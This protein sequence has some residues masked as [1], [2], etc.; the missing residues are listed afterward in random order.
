VG[1]APSNAGMSL[2]LIWLT[3]ILVII[4]LTQNAR[5]LKHSAMTIKLVGLALILV[6]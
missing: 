4:A 6:L 2:K 5:A 1:R 3:L